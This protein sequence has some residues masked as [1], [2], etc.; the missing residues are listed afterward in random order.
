MDEVF[1]NGKKF[2]TKVAITEE[3]QRLG[4]MYQA[5]PPPVMVFAYSNSG[6]RRFWMKNTT[7]PLDIVFCNDNKII[8]IFKGEPLSTAMI[9]P[10]E[11]SNL[12]IELPYGTCQAHGFESGHNIFFKPSIKTLAQILHTNLTSFSY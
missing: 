12:V 2:Q 5:W 11:P 1:I 9:G 6:P 8:K 7:S 10:N 3:E 4:L